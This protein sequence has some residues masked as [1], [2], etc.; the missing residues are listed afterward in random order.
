M[1][2]GS[3]SL[4]RTNWAADREKTEFAPEN[5]ISTP[6]EKTEATVRTFPDGNHGLTLSATG[7]VRELEGMPLNAGV[8]CKDYYRAQIDWLRKYVVPYL[9]SFDPFDSVSSRGVD[10][11]RGFAGPGVRRQDLIER[12]MLDQQV[13]F[14]GLRD[15]LCDL[16]KADLL[17]TK[18]FHSD[19]IGCV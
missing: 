2:R 15:G 7:S 13:G 17:V 19:F 9:T 1:S 3:I 14:H 8:K 18:S 11:R 12:W 4:D 16:S 6:K 10:C 5:R